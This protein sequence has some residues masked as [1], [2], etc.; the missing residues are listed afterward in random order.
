MQLLS[1]KNLSIFQEKSPGNY[2]G[3]V[4]LKKP[5]DFE[6]RSSYDM[7][8]KAT[9]SPIDPGLTLSSTTNILIQVF[10]KVSVMILLRLI[11]FSSKVNDIQDQSPAFLNGPYSSTVPENTAPVS[12]S[13]GQK[14]IL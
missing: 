4:T 13:G 12:L 11:I 7:I 2:V 6:A 8:I 10:K 9:D 1:L 14:C 3:V 5:L